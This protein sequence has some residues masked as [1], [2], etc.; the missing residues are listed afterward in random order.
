MTLFDP[1]EEYQ[2]RFD[3]E[4][5]HGP[6]YAIADKDSEPYYESEYDSRVR[7]L[8]EICARPT[9]IRSDRRYFVDP[10]TFL[11]E[12]ARMVDLIVEA[13]RAVEGPS[14]GRDEARSLILGRIRCG[15][16]PGSP[17]AL[18]A[19]IV[20]DGFAGDGYD[21][22]VVKAFETWGA[23]VRVPARVSA[24]VLQRQGA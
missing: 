11:P 23:I 8:H 21:R 4:A 12:R 1:F 19:R 22:Y 24:R 20:A 9:P 3:F 5:E 18:L 13:M 17:I 7:R 10:E 14:V 2:S 16:M 6:A 15:S